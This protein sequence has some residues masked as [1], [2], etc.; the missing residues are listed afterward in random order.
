MNWRRETGPDPSLA[1]GAYFALAGTLYYWWATSIPAREN[2]SRGVQLWRSGGQ[3]VPGA[4]SQRA[5]GE[6]AWVMEA[7]CAW[8]FGEILLVGQPSI[9]EAIA[10]AKKLNDTITR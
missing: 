10:L 8:H 1:V 5:C 2:A 9:T 3:L 7:L 6:V 4:G